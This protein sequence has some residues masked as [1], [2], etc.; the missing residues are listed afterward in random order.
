MSIYQ[1][2]I[3]NSIKNGY[4]A[5]IMF[6]CCFSH[7]IGGCVV[8]LLRVVTVNPELFVRTLFSRMTL[9]DIFTTFKIR[10]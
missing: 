4:K 2:L 3:L 10:D 8:S 6:V 1:R 7:C 9:K 5:V